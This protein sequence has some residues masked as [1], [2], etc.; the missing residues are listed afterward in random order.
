MKSA[1][2]VDG[3]CRLFMI[4]RLS[5]GV[6]YDRNYDRYDRNYDR[7]DRNYD[8]YDRNYD[9]YDRNYDHYDRNYDRYD[10]NYDHYDRNYDRYDRN[11][12]RLKIKLLF[13]FWGNYPFSSIRNFLNEVILPH[14]YEDTTDFSQFFVVCIT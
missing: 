5:N 2:S 14:T 13:S 12:D 10:R 9:H 1:Y 4:D 3:M 11:Y 8:H 6:T 7:Y